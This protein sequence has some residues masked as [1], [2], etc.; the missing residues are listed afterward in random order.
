MAYSSTIVI[1]ELTA[2]S[3]KRARTLILQG[4]GLPFAGAEWGMRSRVDTT[5]YQ[6]NG[7]EAT[8]QVLGPIELPSKWSGNWS[9]V[10]LGKEPC[11]YQDE[12]GAR[13]DLVDPLSLVNA[14]EA[15]GRAGMRLRVT[16]AQASSDDNASLNGHILREGRIAD[17]R[18]KVM[19]LT[20]IAWEIDFDWMSR[21]ATATKVTSVRP[22]TVNA[23]CAAYQNAINALLIA[24]AIA[25]AQKFNPSSLTLG[26][27]EAVADTPT[28]L[29]NQLA[30]QVQ[31]LQSDA[32]KLA[33]IANTLATQ[34]L[35]VA[36]RAIS[37]A[38]NTVSQ[39]N[40]FQDT[41]T[42]MPYESQTTKTKFADFISSAKSFAQT[43]DLSRAASRAGALFA[44]QLAQ[45]QAQSP[46]NQAIGNPQNLANA[47]NVQQ[48]Y[49]TKDGD[50]PQR[51]SQRFYQ[52]PDHAVDILHTNKLPWHLPLFA[53]HTIL[54]I[55][56]L[57][58]LG[59]SPTQ[60]A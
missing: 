40:N 9:R 54:I 8:Q 60:Q 49:I 22:A 20:D 2:A 15:I 44:A 28:L 55:P 4:P 32:V 26:Q 12:N 7:D 25:Q 57:S 51:V 47:N 56:A 41:L 16:W 21:G 10:Q 34:P 30:R 45:W 31:E 14:C 52:T 35:Q 59:T 3:G 46:N 48:T 36:N 39:T 18:F 23:N 38:R 37:L 33:G 1:Q 42:A 24:S 53:S 27:L 29:A 13:I 6:G 43:G 5:W 58:T 11:S 17:L 19:R 50:T